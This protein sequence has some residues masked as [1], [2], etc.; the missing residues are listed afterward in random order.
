MTILQTFKNIFHHSF[1]QTIGQVLKFSAFSFRV[2][3]VSTAYASG[4]ICDIKVYLSMGFKNCIIIDSEHTNVPSF[5]QT[6][7]LKV[8]S[9]ER[10]PRIEAKQ[11]KPK[12][13]EVD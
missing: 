2:S 11:R 7:V 6:E 4:N 10:N 3:L 9:V 12:R 8:A 5:A 13:S 1:A